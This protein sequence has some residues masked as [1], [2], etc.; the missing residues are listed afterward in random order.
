M[1]KCN[2]RG[3]GLNSLPFLIERLGKEKAAAF[4]L[5][6]LISTIG[7]DCQPACPAF[8]AFLKNGGR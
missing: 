6:I 2:I 4:P 7:I 3:E 8:D 5:L 1:G